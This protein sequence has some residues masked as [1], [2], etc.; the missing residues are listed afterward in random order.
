MVSVLVNALFP[1][2][3]LTLFLYSHQTKSEDFNSFSNETN[4]E[5]SNIAGTCNLF[6]GKW[7][8]DASY[9]LYD[10]ST[11]PFID[12]Q[13]NCQKHGRKDK[14]YQKYRWM[15]FSCNMPRFNGLNFL[16][17][18]KG[19]KIMFVGDSLSLNQFN[20]LA[21]MI[22]AAVPN[23]RST[24]RQRDAISSVTFEEYGLELFLYRTAYLVD[25]DHDK[26]GRVLKLDSIKSGEAWRGMDV[27]IF[28]T[29]HWWTHTGSSQ[30]WDYIQEN[31][32]LYK[33]MNR[34]VAFYKGLQTWARWV[35]MNV[36]PAQTK[37]FFL[38]ISPVHYQGRDW[39]QPTKSC[40][41]EKVPYFGLKYPGGTP[42]AWMVVN[43]VLRK[44]SKPVY[45]LDVTTLSQY[46]KDAH[47]EGYSGVMATDC[48]H[49]CL[50]GLPDTWNQLLYAALSH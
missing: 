41:S 1:T 24:F 21:C 33:D 17:G 34:F 11:C 18:N 26:E 42:M 10:P 27:L 48:S 31:K 2:L 20:S 40:M 5:V 50:P 23:S 13:F 7:V 29:W 38:G 46:R 47:P 14:L 15:P 8:Y 37:V 28:N 22:H 12:P 49:W 25:L 44:M 35:E 19:K 6:R 39:N 32:K 4:F 3:F 30:P 36:N 45:F 9:P 43:K 16:K